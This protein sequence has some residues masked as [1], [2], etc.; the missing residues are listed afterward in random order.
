MLFSNKKKANVYTVA[1]YNVE[2]LFDVYDNPSTHDEDFLPTSQK[3]WTP[4][5]YANKIR[6]LGYAISKVGKKHSGKL[7]SIV[8]LAEVENKSVIIDL[9]D[10][11]HLKN[12]NY[13]FV[14]FDSPD[15][16]GID[17]AL[18]YDT[19]KFTELRSKTYKIDLKNEFG[20]VD[21]TR[22]I[23]LVS[24]L[25]NDEKVHFIVNHWPSRRSG[26]DE[27]EEKRLITSRKVSKIIEEINKREQN[28]KIIIMGDFN[29]DPSSKSLKSLLERHD[30]F[31][32]METLLS[33]TRGSLNHKFNWNLFDQILF[34]TNFFEYEK[35]RHR[36][37]H[38]NIFDDIFLTQFKGKYKGNPFRTF[39][40]R[41]YKGGFSDHFPVY[42]HLKK[43]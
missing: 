15:E 39:V 16:R 40:G 11:K 8:G 23:L 4:K 14:H 7:P 30:L 24:G 27:T 22:D 12:T 33:F 25:F 10:S 21:Y 18:L 36:F 17:V 20:G 32:P 13:N 5:R 26:K 43:H 29:D 2:N 9:I 34:T 37:Y 38:A 3:K 31:N 19:T 6:K 35:E 1:F 41:K 42:I 28:P